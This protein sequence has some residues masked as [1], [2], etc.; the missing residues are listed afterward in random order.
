[1]A[2][3]LVTMVRSAR[4][5]EVIEIRT[6]IAHPTETGYR[7]GEDGRVRPRDLIR[8]FSCHD[9][10]GRSDELVFSADL[11]STFASWS[12]PSVGRPADAVTVSIETSLPRKCRTRSQ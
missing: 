1:M 10:D 11:K 7:P 9:D 6:L 5:G 2:R 8:R 3:A 4:R 12:L